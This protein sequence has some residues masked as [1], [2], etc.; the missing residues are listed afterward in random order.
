MDHEESWE[1]NWCFWTVVLEKIP[2]SPLDLNEIKSVHPKGNQSWRFIETDSVSAEAETPILWPPNVKKWLLKKNPWCWERLKS[3]GEGENRMRWLDGITY[4]RDMSVS[5]LRELAMDREVGRVAVHGVAKCH[6]RLSNWTELNWLGIYPLLD[7]QSLHKNILWLLTFLF[8]CSH[9]RI[10]FKI[11][12]C[13][14]W[15]YFWG[16]II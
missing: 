2:E 7:V 14:F 16:F 15:K 11:N 13:E 10:F 6:T 9:F 8:F 4:L 12:S 3:G 5:K 1:N